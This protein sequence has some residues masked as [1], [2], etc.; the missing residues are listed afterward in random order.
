MVEDLLYGQLAKRLPESVLRK[1]YYAHDRVHWDQIEVCF[2]VWHADYLKS[3]HTVRIDKADWLND[4]SIARL[5][6][7]CP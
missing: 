4:A 6:L 5:C 3:Y 1:I 2:Y 7:E